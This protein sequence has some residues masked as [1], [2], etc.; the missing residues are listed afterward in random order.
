[1]VP[2][3]RFR[4][5]LDVNAAWAGLPGKAAK[6]TTTS[7]PTHALLLP[8]PLSGPRREAVGSGS[9]SKSPAMLVACASDS[10]GRVPFLQQR[11]KDRL[12]S[13]VDNSCVLPPGALHFLSGVETALTL[14]RVCSKAPVGAGL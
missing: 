2:K 3:G 6:M 11:W 8:T 13:D 1:M 12:W 10:T 9:P 7:S 4:R 5:E 14:D